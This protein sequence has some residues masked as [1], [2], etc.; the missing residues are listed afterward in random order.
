MVLTMLLFSLYHTTAFSSKLRTFEFRLSTQLE[1][2]QDDLSESIHFASAAVA[3]ASSHMTALSSASWS[4][5]SPPSKSSRS[6]SHPDK[7]STSIT[8]PDDLS[9]SITIVNNE[10]R[11]VNKNRCVI[12]RLFQMQL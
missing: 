3:V 8:C 6:I 7:L 2:S 10:I 4:R 12:P 9:Q 11:L 1:W 5:F